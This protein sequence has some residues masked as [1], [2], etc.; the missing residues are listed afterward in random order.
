[1]MFSSME[2]VTLKF[3]FLTGLKISKQNHY[4][5]SPLV[6]MKVNQKKTLNV[7][8]YRRISPVERLS[9]FKHLIT[10]SRAS[11]AH[12]RR[13]GGGGGGRLKFIELFISSRFQAVQ[14]QINR[15]VFFSGHQDDETKVSRSIDWIR[16]FPIKT[17]FQQQH[18][19][20][21]QKKQASSLEKYLKITIEL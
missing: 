17:A 1:M 6:M 8:R 13:F 12:E 11:L 21:Y 16:T 9:T 2:K 10:F 14:T 7:F 18:I 5:I 4:L 3:R 20:S 15:I 19:G